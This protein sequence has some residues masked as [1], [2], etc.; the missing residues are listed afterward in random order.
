LFIYTLVLKSYL[1]ILLLLYSIFCAFVKI[2]RKI[3]FLAFDIALHCLL[4]KR[5]RI[6][7]STKQITTIERKKKANKFEKRFYKLTFFDKRILIYIEAIYATKLRNCTISSS[8]S[9]NESQDLRIIA[10]T[11]STTRLEIVLKIF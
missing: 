6:Q 9:K 1:S 7:R 11:F 4:R 5:A 2:I 3:F 10:T 8:S